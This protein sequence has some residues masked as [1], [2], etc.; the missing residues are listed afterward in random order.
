[1]LWFCFTLFYGA[2]RA[3]AEDRCLTPVGYAAMRGLLPGTELGAN[4]VGMRQRLVF[5]AAGT[6][7]KDISSMGTMVQKKKQLTHAATEF[8]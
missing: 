1:M 7:C 4:S 8:F 2:T 6:T 5:S 3:F